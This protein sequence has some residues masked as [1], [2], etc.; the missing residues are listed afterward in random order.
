M[1]A[2]ERGA[3]LQDAYWY[4][5]RAAGGDDMF[6]G[7]YSPS[8]ALRL[9]LK[10]ARRAGLHLAGRG[11]RLEHAKGVTVAVLAFAES[12]GL[13]ARSGEP[14]V[15]FTETTDSGA[16]ACGRAPGVVVSRDPWTVT[17][18][19]CVAT[20]APHRAVESRKTIHAGAARDLAVLQA[21]KAQQS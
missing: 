5:E 21:Y 7:A 16:T 8:H 3:I 9:A 17:C 10:T 19:R 12:F 1:K 4:A 11:L 14:F 6:N 20:G 15:H 18:E 13:D 2:R